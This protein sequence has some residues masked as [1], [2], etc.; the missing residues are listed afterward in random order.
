MVLS[1]LQYRNLQYRNRTLDNRQHNLHQY[2]TGR[3]GGEAP[4]SPAVAVDTAN[5]A[6][7]ANDAAWLTLADAT[8]RT[9]E[10][11]TGSR[12]QAKHSTTLNTTDTTTPA[13]AP[14]APRSMRGGMTAGLA[15]QV[16]GVRQA[17]I[18]SPTR[19]SSGQP[20]NQRA[21]SHGRPRGRKVNGRNRGG[22]ARNPTD[23]PR[24]RKTQRGGR[25]R[26]QGQANWSLNPAAADFRPSPSFAVQDPVDD[27][28]RID[29][30]WSFNPAPNAFEAGSGL[31]SADPAVQTSD[32]STQ[33]KSSDSLLA[34]DKTDTSDGD[35]DDSDDTVIPE[36]HKRPTGPLPDAA[37][38]PPLTYN[39][40]AAHPDDTWKYSNVPRMDMKQEFDEISHLIDIGDFD[41]D[42][43]RR[44]AEDKVEIENERHKVDAALDAHLPSKHAYV[45]DDG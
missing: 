4:R 29:S 41:M 36:R 34:T 31:P 24:G 32:P 40:E 39:D 11:R 5:P 38:L 1:N 23:E 16:R 35:S 20:V 43:E 6:S 22:R 7:A 42:S 12:T 25:R 37:Y 19:D 26:T 45:E 44:P 27:E 14:T 21:E 15:R 10:P 9:N 30:A 18:P 2:Q 17:N 8:T 28:T 13:D 33:S 3:I